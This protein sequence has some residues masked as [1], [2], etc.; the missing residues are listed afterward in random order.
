MGCELVSIVVVEKLFVCVIVV[1]NGN[2]EIVF[3]FFFYVVYEMDF[4]DNL[5][6][7]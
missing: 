5:I 1:D 4:C 7:I 3:M 6:G 2:V